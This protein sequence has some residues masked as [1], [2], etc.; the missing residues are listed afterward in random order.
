LEKIE[1]KKTLVAVAALAAVSGAMAEATLSGAV[2]AGMSSWSDNGIIATTSFKAFGDRNSQ[3][4]D[5][6]VTFSGSE[7]LGDGLKA[8]FKLEPRVHVSGYDTGAANAVI[9]G[10]ANSMFGANREA[11][12]GVGGAFGS[13][14]I[15]NNYSPM[16]IQAVAPYDV[17][18]STNSPGYLVSNLTT[19]NNTNSIEYV[20]P[21]LVQGLSLQLNKN[22]GHA[23][24]LAASATGNAGDATGYG[25]T[26]ASS[27]FSVSYAGNTA[28]NTALSDGI[29]TV[30]AA[31]TTSDLVKSAWGLS[32]DFGVAK[33]SAQN[34]TAKLSTSNSVAYGYG[35][36]VPVGALKFTAS[37]ST[38]DNTGTSPDYVGT[39]YGG[40]YAFSK[41]TSAYLLL[42]KVT[43]STAKTLSINTLG[44]VHNF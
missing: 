11:W 39:Q 26:Y 36:S 6:F 14:H 1:M 34:A 40:Y 2:N 23:S 21:T 28:K 10:G 13:I 20:A 38:L 30:A 19:F 29:N 18:G 7:D 44:L 4:G 15:G 24:T 27:G 8:S 35:V 37:Y 12:V 25:L 41:K 42:S 9:G 17:N 43:S 31:S 33:V 22:Y 32:Y 5:S 16:F 3:T